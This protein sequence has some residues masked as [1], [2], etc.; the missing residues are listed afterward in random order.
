M[1]G[2]CHLDLPQVSPMVKT[3]PDH[4]EWRSFS[5][6][7]LSLRVLLPEHCHYMRKNVHSEE[8]LFAR[9]CE[10]LQGDY[11]KL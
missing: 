9:V 11:H 4:V 1:E 5:L 10:R 3:D 6:T 2:I 7:V 8:K